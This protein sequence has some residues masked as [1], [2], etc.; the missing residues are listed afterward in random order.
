MTDR[1]PDRPDPADHW[2][3]VAAAWSKWWPLIEAGARP[4]SQTMLDLV[5]LKP[6]DRVLDLASGIGEPAALAAERVGPEGH[7]LATDLAPTMVALGRARVDR[8]GLTNIEFRQMDASAPDLPDGGFDVVL[9]RWGLMF[10]DDLEVT[11]TRLHDLLAPGGRLAIAVWG[12]PEEVPA[13]SLAGR[14]L[15]R[16]LDLAPPAEDAATP[17]DLADIAALTRKLAAAGFKAIESR[18]VSVVYDFASD[19]E[20]LDYRRDLSPPDPAMARIPEERRAAAWHAVGEALA[21][22]R[23]IEGRVV[24]ENLSVCLAARRD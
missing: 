18:S 4:V 9:C 16:E 2:E 5:A 12:P 15:R 6:G 17:F 1:E 8:L 19:Q 3:K 21:P 23:T 10:I 24:M 11:L 20:Y 7:V 22:Y 14:I 13:I